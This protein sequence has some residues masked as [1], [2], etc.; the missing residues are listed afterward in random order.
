MLNKG[1]YIFE[2]IQILDVI[3]SSMQDYQDKKAPLM[4]KLKLKR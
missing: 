1:P 2:A 4:P 3:I